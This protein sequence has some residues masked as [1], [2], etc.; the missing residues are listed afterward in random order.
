MT[1]SILFC[2]LVEL[3]FECGIQLSV[4]LEIMDFPPVLYSS[5]D[6]HALWHLA[7]VPV[8]FFWFR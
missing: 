5:I 6:S 8:P 3:T 1:C 4:V 2:S 7:T